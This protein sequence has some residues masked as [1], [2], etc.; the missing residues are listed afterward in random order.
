MAAG[1]F[2][3]RR[4]VCI[5]A[6]ASPLQCCQHDRF[7]LRDYHGVF[8]LGSESTT[9]ADDGWTL[10]TEPGNFSAQYEYTMVITRNHPIVLTTKRAAA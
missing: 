6:L 7:I 3:L 4:K 10:L 9:T 1:F 5:A 2:R 8:V